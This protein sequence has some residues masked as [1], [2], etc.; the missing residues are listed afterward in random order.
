M[1][2]NNISAPIPLRNKAILKSTSDIAGPR[3]E[4]PS[5]SIDTITTA[6][7]AQLDALK[8]RT[9]DPSGSLKNKLLAA[10]NPT[11][12]T[13]HLIDDRLK[14][15]NLDYPE[16]R[17]EYKKAILDKGSR[18][19][20]REKPRRLDLSAHLPYETETHIDQANYISHILVHLYIAIKS[21]DLEG[22]VSISTKDLASIKNGIEL[23]LDTDFYNT[24][25]SFDY[26]ND[27]DGD[28][29][30]DEDD[31]IKS[32]GV[33]GKVLPRSATVVSVNH[34]TNEL[35]TCLKMKY[36]IPLTLRAA[37][38]KVYYYLALS[39]GQNVQVVLFIDMFV[40]L[41]FKYRDLLLEKEL[42]VLNHETM[43]DHMKQFFPGADV[44]FTV[45]SPQSSESD[46]ALLSTMMRLALNS[47]C[48]FKKDS[49]KFIF[50]WCTE[51]FAPQ[52]MLTAST[53]LASM[54]PIVF[55]K[56]NNAMEF[57]PA[58]LNFWNTGIGKAFE[59]NLLDL[60]G[61]FAAAAFVKFASGDCEVKP[62]KY[63][64]FTEAQ[65]DFIFNKI[66]TNLRIT[67]RQNSFFGIARV[68][69]YSITQDNFDDL[70]SK[71]NTL[72]KSLETYAHP[73]NSGP[74]SKLIARFSHRF[75]SRYHKRYKE[76]E[77][78]E[79][80]EPLPEFLVLT[81][82]IN[83]K[84][85]SGFTEVV[86]LGSQSKKDNDA[87]YHVSAI[88]YLADLRAP[89][90]F[91]ILDKI[92]M[93]LYQSLTDQFV[94]S[95]HRIIVAL[96]QFTEVSRFMINLPVYRVHI[97]NLLNL[98]LSKIGSNDI[99]LNNSI[100][101][102]F[103]TITSSLQLK[104]L[105]TEEDLVSFE[106]TTANFINDHL[107]FIKEHP[108]ELF[109]PD[110]RD[111]HNAFIGSTKAFKDIIRVFIEKIVVLLEADLNDRF[112]FKI[113]QTILIFTEAL[114][115]EEFEFYGKTI[116]EKVLSG[117]LPS[118]DGNE[119]LIA[120]LVASVVKRDNSK[121]VEFFE[122]TEKLIR[123]E[124]EQ[125]AGTVRN[126]TSKLLA[127]DYKLVLY[128]TVISEV[129]A[130]SN[131]TV[132]AVGPELLKLVKDLFRN[133]KNPALVTLCSYIVHKTLKNLT[134][135]KLKE[136]RMFQT[137]PT[138]DD[139][140]SRW[141]AK[142]F[143][144]SRFNTENLQFDWYQ[145][146]NEE[147]CF[148]IEL[149][150]T[151]IVE[152]LSEL[153]ES[154]KMNSSDLAFT[155]GVYKNLLYIGNA[156]SGASMLF[157]PDYNNNDTSDDTF[158]KNTLEQKLKILKAL[159]SSKQDDHEMNIDIEEIT[160]PEEDIECDNP[161]DTESY[162]DELDVNRGDTLNVD[163][164]E[165]LAVGDD[166][167]PASRILSPSTP[168]D[169]DL[170]SVMN[171]AI[172]FRG[173]KIYNCNYFF[174]KTV[175][176][177]RAY[178][179]YNHV[180]ELRSLVGQG[181]HKLFLF[182]YANLSENTNLFQTLLHTLRT[183]FCDVGKESSFDL[184]DQLFI[185]YTFLKKVQA[186]GNYSKPFSRTLLAARFEKYH[187]QRVILHSTNRFKTKLDKILLKD[188]T[189]L[190]TSAYLTVYQPAQV[191]M[192]ETIKKLIG[193]YSFVLSIL[194]EDLETF[195]NSKDTKR[196]ESAL[197]ILRLKKFH[198]K[199]LQDYKH[200]PK[201][202][203]LC[204][205]ALEIDDDDVHT[206]AQKCYNDFASSTKVPSA[207]A[208]LE[209][210]EIDTAIRPPDKCIDLEINTVRA[211]KDIKRKEY[212]DIL[213]GLQTYVLEQEA[214]N[215]HWKI[216]VLHIKFLAYLQSYY[217]IETKPEI[218]KLIMEKSN[219]HHPTL[220]KACLKALGKIYDKI[221]DF[222]AYDYSLHNSFD[223]NFIRKSEVKIDTSKKFKE[224]FYN[225]MENYDDPEFFID[226]S[227]FK[228]F[229]FWSD[230]LLAMKPGLDD[231]NEQL[232]ESDRAALK[233]IGGFFTKEWI[234][235]VFE[236]LSQ[237]NE[238]KALF[239]GANVSLIASIIQMCNA[240][241]TKI[242]YDDFIYL[243]DA[244]YDKDD[245]STAIIST[246]VICGLLTSTK[247]STEEQ[248]TRRDVAI[249]KFFDLVLSTDLTP[250]TSSV[251]HILFWW[252]TSK[253][254]FR[255]VPILRDLLKELMTIDLDS[256]SA[257]ITSAR[258]SFA[259]AYVSSL[260]RKFHHSKQLFESLPLNHPYQ[261]VRHSV[262]RMMILFSTISSAHSFE[263]FEEFLHF[264]NQ[265]DIGQSVYYYDN[266]MIALFTEI[267]DD[268][269]KSRL[270]V[271]H[272]SVQEVLHSEYYYR[273]A[274]IIDWLLGLLSGASAVGLTGLIN[275]H[276]APF[277][278]RLVNNRELCKLGS[279]HP[280]HVYINLSFL[281]FNNDTIPA[282][283]QLINVEY[284][285]INQLQ[286]Q[287][288]FIEEFFSHQ[289]LQL[290][291]DQ[292]VFILK[293][294]NV[295]LFHT[296]VEIRK[297]ASEV[298][299]GIIHNS[300]DLTIVEEFLSKYKKTLSK[301]K[302]KKQLSNEQMIKL[303]GSTIG[304][305]ALISAFP[306][307]SPPPEWMP[308]QVYTLTKVSSVSG[309][310]GKSAK[311]ILSNFKKLRADTWHID[312]ESFTEE[313]LEGLEGVL[314]R[315]YFA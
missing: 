288:S 246:E 273:A 53:I 159:R 151:V 268:T 198:A 128:I 208:I 257:F 26:E 196:I 213:T 50:E 274:T 42:L 52:T 302:P 29:G 54:L 169:T 223:V 81:E 88:C 62:E 166:T 226:N 133:V 73:S 114:G 110:E 197:R 27:E 74:W 251:W 262:A 97:T 160:K 312:R 306:Y 47:N 137:E 176:E 139:I 37:L 71:L 222:A 301:S 244:L 253:V 130:V 84:I 278:M 241:F 256:D 25:L 10:T 156:L 207:V 149:F 102:V 123:F 252:Q 229:Y 44:S 204:E 40:T 269:E 221:V 61:R 187:R 188:I 263:S 117:D 180:H 23:T 35:K 82:E 65:L 250:E 90:Q 219:T 99:N 11:N 48:F 91:Q 45:Y 103:V 41:T 225:E 138:K 167:A 163:I 266:D 122:I 192:I 178:F 173:L 272:L 46:K 313:Q 115:P 243:I 277:L 191:V 303:H 145:P 4:R 143:D 9:P 152:A 98:L 58:I 248:C 148:A 142:Q 75:I 132:L 87:N 49:M 314:W 79:R 34:W 38:A 141:G 131:G 113:T 194:I 183:Y 135:I 309:L 258:L 121:T 289:L 69:V 236:T 109:K 279:L 21:L 216:S 146:G 282:I 179:N 64:I 174:G 170:N 281:P 284:S 212:I 171:S 164:P 93:D 233:E 36:E 140:E 242:E 86:L 80:D 127:A 116:K 184:D 92:L 18:F 162:K 30:D 254:D 31:E 228:G 193:S 147:I 2:R 217:E 129:M 150:E 72:L 95:S 78:E 270:A 294:I 276:I 280:D 63:L 134:N 206:L 264:E 60:L 291:F 161:T 33:I 239:Q 68:L 307:A 20:S 182:L 190:S 8:A 57:I 305:G 158:N 66:Q 234:I 186:I 14:H 245:K 200:M 5:T 185:D 232:S 304:I 172:A 89:N 177:K 136:N 189:L 70:Y 22:L 101:N 77:S 120:N 202:L 218:I 235:S 295:L 199:I 298:L 215:D 168:Q 111:L 55:E 13:D 299:S 56:D 96:K 6:K 16:D 100:F 76:Q 3:I 43:L 231:L 59:V 126:M 7:G 201:L 165:K 210:G 296:S 175:S 310:V 39:T 315:S 237:D 107:F 125:G 17:E 220:L 28:E 259:A 1:S 153:E 271:E 249:S 260:G 19:F 106:S 112:I 203:S 105:S 51:K 261:M 205:L 24:E 230:E 144:E 293:R 214:K 211:A 267:F 240:G 224:K 247:Y 283:L 290:T 181:L 154:N 275:S 227:H 32:S 118:V 94:N 287:L 265:S 209:I 83:S 85:I 15:Y 285:S 297:K 195:I 300:K 311:D 286:L 292:K 157:D 104:D 67:Q 308:E 255:R 155:D 119:A 12:Q 124:M 238:S 108:R